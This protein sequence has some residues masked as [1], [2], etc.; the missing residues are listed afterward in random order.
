MARD[1]KN[2]AEQQA[3]MRQQPGHQQ[4]GDGDCG[5][6]RGDAIS[7]TQAQPVFDR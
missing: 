7:N 1:L 3:R 2:S 6:H 4:H 5:N